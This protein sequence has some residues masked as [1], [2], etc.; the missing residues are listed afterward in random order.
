[1]IKLTYI[2]SFSL[3]CASHMLL[4]NEPVKLRFCYEDKQLLPY[5]A[6]NGAQIPTPPGATIEHLQEGIALVP[7]LKVTFERRPWLRCLQLLE[8]N[9]VDA[10]VATYNELRLSFAVFPLDE[11]NAPDSRLALNQH[12]TCI[13]QRVGDN[14]TQRLKD[15]VVMAR[16]LG[17]VVPEYPSGVSI[18]PVQSQQQAFSLVK[19]GRVD[20]TTTTCEIN[21]VQLPN[22]L[23]EQLEVIHPP[24]Y[25]STG[26]L[27]F[28]KAFYNQHSKLATELWRTLQQTQ[29]PNRYYQYL[30]Q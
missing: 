14:V 30:P 16:P 9:K 27:V 7:Q 23:N 4:A 26:Y 29:N 24:L 28:S 25:E 17:Y 22:M 6:G 11:N 20:A 18:V 3:L 12:A 2:L 15:G 19:L 8:Q 13:V 10:V 5:Y 1:M 21:T